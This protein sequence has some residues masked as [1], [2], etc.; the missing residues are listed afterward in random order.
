LI[1]RCKT[2]QDGGLGRVWEAC[3]VDSVGVCVV[4]ATILF[5]GRRCE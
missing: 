5:E 3:A 1:R 2:S 4:S